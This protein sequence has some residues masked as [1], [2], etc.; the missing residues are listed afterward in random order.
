MRIGILARCSVSATALALASNPAWASQATGQQAGTPTEV[1]PASAGASE[2]S[3]PPEIVVSGYREALESQQAIRRNSEQVVDAIVA[4]D[5]GK[6]PDI[7]VSDTAARIPGVQVERGGGEAGRVLVRGLPDFA[8]TYN[9]REIFTAETRS[10]ALQDFPSG[11]IGAIE[12]Y[13]TSTADLIEPG[14][15]GL[16]NVRSRRPFD[17]DGFQVA[18]SAWGLYSH[19]A[20]NVRP[21][22]NIVVS[23]RWE[24]G[25]SE[26]GALIGFSYTDLSYL[27]S[28]R[29][30]TDFVAGGGPNGTRFPDIQRIT[31]GVGHRTRPSINFALQ[32]SPNPDVELYAEGLWQGFRNR[33]SDRETSVPL[34][35]GSGFSDFETQEGRPDLLE[36]GTVTDPFRPDG[37]QGGTFNKT[38]TYQAAIGGTWDAGA[39]QIAADLAFTDSTFTGSTASVDFAFANRQT[40]TF[41]TDTDARDGGAEF[42]FGNFDPSNPAN[43][44]YRGFYE[45]AQQATGEDIQARLDFDYDT[46]MS[47]LP[48]VEF[49]V[50]YTDREA[51]REFGNRYWGFEGLRLPFSAVPL[52]YQLFDAGFRGSDAQGGYRN[53]LAPTYDSI[54]ANLVQLRQFNRG[55]GGTAFGVAS[56]DPPPPDP[57]Q[58]W[59]AAE[60][61]FSAY[62]QARYEFDLGGDVT[63]DGVV[64]L[65]YAKSDLTLSGTQLV[66]PAG[67]GAGVFTPTDVDRE[68]E[69][70]LPNVN[71]RIRFTPELQ[72]RLA[73]T[74]TRTRP[75]FID[76]RASGTLDQPP[77][78]LQQTPIPENCF[79]T[80]SGGNP[81]LNPLLSDNYDVTLEYY[82]SRNGFV[83]LSLF[84][85]DMEGFIEN[86][87]F[88]G[89]TPD[90]VPL[91]LG[92]PINS[93]G[94]EIR[95][96]EVQGSTF[97]DFLGLPQFGIQANLTHLDASADFEYD[98]GF[99]NGVRRVDT[100]NR[101]LLGVSDWSYNLIG[102]FETGGLSA[103]L[104]YNW[105]SEFPLTYQRRGDHLYTEEADPVSRLDLSVSYDLFDSLTVFGD[106]TNILGDP[107]SSTLTRTD[108]AFPN[109]APTGFT[110]TFPRVVRYEET[111]VSLGVRFRF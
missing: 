18:G 28:T 105:R 24:A 97:F 82:F 77:T 60:Q 52:D 85:R 73:Y 67:G 49:G 81:F 22:G 98:E 17:F 26:F 107:F 56:D 101:E 61:N 96:F 88:Q 90:G 102:I 55:L 83:T 111:T 1:Q 25:E 34:W 54:R 86:S 27:D 78:C 2:T 75:S 21:N 100:V 45:E 106:W 91:R 51:H 41:D 20:E 38:N 7:A 47:L 48:R 69:D 99:V 35:G 43:Y 39:L 6:L 11:L 9:G 74:Q 40:V 70:W 59:D 79:Q 87:V 42:S 12:V 29:S 32:W 68:F 15:A 53:W 23:N 66:I 92:G 37:F 4:D 8:T 93:G 84:H 64:G 50:R 72:A 31:Y 30:N 19:Q 13:K 5:I 3:G 80:G 108:V 16:I 95:G 89:L 110:A 104:A 36:S 103:R 94:G 63:I 57:L 65:R 62:V 44:V 14:L 76:L 10:V 109:G 58:T 71:A 46:G 33:L